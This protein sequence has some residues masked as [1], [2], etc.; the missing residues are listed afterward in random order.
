MIFWARVWVVIISDTV[1]PVYAREELLG[2]AW[3][4]IVRLWDEV[5]GKELG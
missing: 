5:N 2:S 4:D 1:G 3:E